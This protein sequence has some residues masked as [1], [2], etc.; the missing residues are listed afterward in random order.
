MHPLIKVLTLSIGTLLAAG[1]SVAT[2]AQETAAHP[3]QGV[4]SGLGIRN[5]G[6]ATM[7]RP[8]VPVTVAVSQ[9]RAPSS[10]R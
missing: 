9:R 4:V 3:D 10:A 1:L 7:R 6:S 5:I 8:A 2:H